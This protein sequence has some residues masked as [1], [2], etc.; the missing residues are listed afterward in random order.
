MQTLPPQAANGQMS[1]EKDQSEVSE[2]NEEAARIEEVLKDLPENQQ[3]AVRLKFQSELSYKEIGDVLDLPVSH[4]GYLIRT[5]IG[6][7]R[8][9]LGAETT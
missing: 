2:Q 5:A 9:E 6:R 3:E 8:K 4:V 1:R 7:L